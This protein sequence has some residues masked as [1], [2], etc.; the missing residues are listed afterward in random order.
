MKAQSKFRITAHFLKDK[1]TGSYTAIVDQIPSAIAQGK[2][3]ETAKENLLTSIY[4]SLLYQSK[5]SG[6]NVTSEDNGDY[7]T[8]TLELA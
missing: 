6:N 5:I 2:D 1:G 4:A 3:F 7:I 8:E